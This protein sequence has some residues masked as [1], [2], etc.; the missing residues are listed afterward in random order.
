MQKCD[1]CGVE[2]A[3]GQTFVRES[4]TFSRAKVF[5]PVC[6]A[7]LNGKFL[8]AFLLLYVAA[9]LI[10][11][12]IL[13]FS[14]SSEGGSFMV[15]CFLLQFFIIVATVPHELAHAFVAKWFK[16]NV[17]KVIVGFGSP[18]LRCRLFG[19]PFEFRRVPMGGITLFVPNHEPWHRLKYFLVVMAGPTINLVFFFAGYFFCRPG[20]LSLGVHQPLRIP[21]L[22]ALANI[23][24]VIEN[25]IPYQV[26]TLG[27]GTASDGLA[28]LQMV[29]GTGSGEVGSKRQLTMKILG[30]CLRIVAMLFLSLC[31]V[32]CFGICY[33]VLTD[34]GKL[35][36]RSAAFLVCLMGGL[37]GILLFFVYR[38]WKV[39]GGF[40]KLRGGGL[41]GL[42][43]SSPYAPIQRDYQAD[44]MK[45]ASGGIEEKCFT[46]LMNM[47]ARNELNELKTRIT[48]LLIIAPDQLRIQTLLVWVLGALQQHR[49]AIA[50][51]DKLLQRMDV[52]KSTLTGFRLGRMRCLIS[53]GKYDDVRADCESFI[54]EDVSLLEKVYVLDCLACL[55]HMSGI[56]DYL[57]EADRWSMMASELAP[58]LVTLQGTRGAVLADQGR[59][60]EARP[61]LEKVYKASGADN[62]KGIA[63]LFLALCAKAEGDAKA[64]T[65]WARKAARIYPEN[66]VL[67]RIEK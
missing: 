61:I 44:M 25:L 22:F 65:G 24:V 60:S 4:I 12:A 41:P 31:S 16:F 51:L 48:E 3:P 40:P 37:G 26:S 47:A 56:I 63:C 9:G 59:Y 52:S 1:V 19:F 23:L 54:T 45:C 30:S 64:A 20:E 13:L 46:E 7:T 49:E 50:V 27:Q 39:K 2:S 10:G 29:F 11:F 32:A 55:P 14:P 58:N 28:M 42:G 34:P 43:N 35:T 67:Q 53:Q 5:C 38:I 21:G 15:K 66:W 17:I 8:G 57:P 6:H 33:F 18:V 62:D 36:W